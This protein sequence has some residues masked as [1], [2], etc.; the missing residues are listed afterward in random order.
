[1]YRRTVRGETNSEL[2]EQ[3]RRN[4]LL[5]PRPVRGGH[6]RDQLPEV[7]RHARSAMSPRFPPP[8][9][10]KSL[11]MPSNQRVRLYHGQELTPINQ[12]SQRDERQPRH[13]IGSPRLDLALEAQRQ[14]L[15]EEQ[16]LGG[17]LRAWPHHRYCELQ[18]VA[19]D[20]H[21]RA[22]VEARTR[23]RHATNC[24]AEQK[25]AAEPLPT[26]ERNSNGLLTRYFTAQAN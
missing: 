21:E 9:Q 25:Q 19:G 8:E 26:H 3:F 5:A 10:A 11:S 17:E 16:I 20:A 2:H 15:A 13:V 18:D 14:L 24:C 1:M 7:R 23:L 12:A 22:N 6:L 4:S